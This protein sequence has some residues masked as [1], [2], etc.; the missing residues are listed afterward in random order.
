MMKAVPHPA[1]AA[2]NTYRQIDL[3]KEAAP[4]LIGLPAYQKAGTDSIQI[5]AVHAKAIPIAPQG[6][7]TRKK[8]AVSTNSTIPHRKQRSALPI[9]MWTQ[10]QVPEMNMAPIPGPNKVKILPLSS[11]FGPSKTKIRSLP[12]KVNSAPSP[13]PTNASM[14]TERSK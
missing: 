5:D 11:H 10:L 6:S 9:E 4:I 12:I 13:M 14:A 2:A 1:I 7:A 3:M 8:A